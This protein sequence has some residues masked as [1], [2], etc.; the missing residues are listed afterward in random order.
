MSNKCNQC[1]MV[2]GEGVYFH[3]ITMSNLGQIQ[4]TSTYIL[5]QTNTEF[6]SNRKNKPE[7]TSRFLYFGQD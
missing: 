3:C 6:T 2:I 5:I 4:T 7:W 1:T